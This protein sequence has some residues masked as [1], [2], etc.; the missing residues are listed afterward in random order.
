MLGRSAGVLVK[1]IIEKP[2]F[3]EDEH[4]D[5]CRVWKPEEMSPCSNADIAR[6]L[7]HRVIVEPG[8]FLATAPPSAIKH[9]VTKGWIVKDS[10]GRFYGVT[11]KAAFELKLPLTFQGRKTPSHDDERDAASHE[12]RGALARIS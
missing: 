8:E 5:H 6:C 1:A 9:A 10:L 11:R 4:R 12:N 3:Y 2:K 7:R